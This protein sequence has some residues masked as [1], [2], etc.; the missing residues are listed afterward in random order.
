[1]IKDNGTP[2]GS[3]APDLFD[4]LYGRDAI[5]GKKLASPPSLDVNIS[6]RARSRVIG[7]SFR[8]L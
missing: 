1:M 4:P 5:L 6:L 3:I 7:E 8:F 2:V